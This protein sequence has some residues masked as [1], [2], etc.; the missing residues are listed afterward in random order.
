MKI[1]GMVIEG[2]Q[3]G[4]KIGFPT[5]NI[6]INQKIDFGIY[7]G[8]TTFDNKSFLSAIYIG[9]YRPNIL[10]THLIDFSDENIYGKEIEVEIQEKIREDIKGLSNEELKKIIT[11]D[12]S[13]IKNV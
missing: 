5:A 4:R 2:K 8:I 10:E 9:E 1:N 6:S 7:K 12:I 3:Q 13:K 11:E